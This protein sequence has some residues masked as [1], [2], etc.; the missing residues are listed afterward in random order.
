MKP[1]PVD[2]SAPDFTLM[3]QI[4]KP[5][6]LREAVQSKKVLLIFYPTDW[7]Q[8]C[9]QELSA[10]RELQPLFDQAGCQLVAI[11]YND[12]I[13]H[14]LWSERLRLRFPL[15]C[16]RLGAVA[17][18][19]GVQDDDEN[20]FNYGRPQ[21]A[22]IMIDQSMTIVWKWVAPS[23]WLEPE[24]NEVLKAATGELGKMIFPYPQM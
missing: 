9:F 13:S 4:G 15:L 1:L 22:L 20:S 3:D 11:S 21:R 19:F 16:D 18:L 23:L 8:V 14:G 24:Y 7:G 6:N 12:I 5:F 17:A 2:S 10:F